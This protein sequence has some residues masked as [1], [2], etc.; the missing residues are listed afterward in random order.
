MGIGPRKCKSNE[1]PPA[2]AASRYTNRPHYLSWVENELKDDLSFVPRL[3]HP[4]KAAC[5]HTQVRVPASRVFARSRHMGVQ[6]INN[7]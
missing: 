5:F 6:A 3:C 1:P 2:G 4:T 7:S